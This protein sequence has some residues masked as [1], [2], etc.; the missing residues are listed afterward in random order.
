MSLPPRR[1][2]T[3][4]RQHHVLTLAT[5]AG[6]IPWVAN[7]FYAYSEKANYFVLTSGA[8]TRHIR[9]LIE[10][11]TV[12]ASIVLETRA[13]GKIRGLQVQGTLEAPPPGLHRETR[14]LY[15]RRFPYAAL[16]D[17][18]LWILRPV[19]MKMTDNRLGFGKKIV[20]EEE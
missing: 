4:I 14:K 12:A 2:V 19:M 5:A 1:A 20:W 13:V 16:M 9:D 17:T 6:N 11:N 3:F 7:C 15:L 18:T 10:G 8:D